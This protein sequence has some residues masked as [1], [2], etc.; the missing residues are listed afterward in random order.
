MKCNVKKIIQFLNYFIIIL[1]NTM[2]NILLKLFYKITGFLAAKYLKKHSPK[3]IGITGWVGK[4][5]C[6]MVVSSALEQ[7][8]PE[9]TIYTSP[10][11]FNSEIGIVLSI[12]KIEVYTP[13]IKNLFSVLCKVLKKT[14]TWK[15]EYDI[16]VLE[17]GV[18]HPK[19]M[20]HLLWVAT[21]D[22]W[23]YTQSDDVHGVYFPPDYTITDEELK[24]IFASKEK[25]Y[26][27]EWDVSVVEKTKKLDVTLYGKQAI[28]PK[29]I[30]YKYEYKKLKSVFTYNYSEV[31][32]TLVWEVNLRYL[33]LA[34]DIA[35]L[36]GMDILTKK[37]SFDIALQPGRY[38]LFE[39]KGNIF[40][41]STY[42]AAPQS[43]KLMIQNTFMLRDELFQNYK[44]GFCLW[45]MREL[46]DKT[47]KDHKEL[48]P[49]ITEADF[50]VTV[51]E[52][53]KKY[54]FKEMIKL[55][56]DKPLENFR[57]S[58]H[59]GEYIKNNLLPKKDKWIVLFKGS[60]NTIFME[61]AIKVLLSDKDK[62]KLVRQS[63]EWK[64]QK[65]WYM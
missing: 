54:I 57:Y 20:D 65:K 12:F 33:C 9:K 62:K 59:A 36:L 10:K 16:L 49:L 17:Y 45:D 29:D 7:L 32:T 41:D 61:E 43:M 35:G 27:F 34:F 18:D 26:V 58:K 53:T 24:L 19:D 47:E 64:I 44:V 13:S 11:N 6:R 37:I 63:D 52:E 55:E 46:W 22:I 14:F 28:V 48:I 2:K 56:Y 3:I 60:Q 51:G 31:E 5:S 50:I 4:T 1:K 40:I 15:K 21:P 30:R 8:F 38:T 25:K 39:E 23:I 42:N